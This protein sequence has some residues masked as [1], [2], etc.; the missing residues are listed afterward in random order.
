MIRQAIQEVSPTQA[1]F[2]VATMERVI[3]ESIGTQR[4]Y[5]W[6]MAVFAGI[7]TLLAAA[8][9]YGV[10]AYLVTLRTR[11]FGIR[12]ALGA[13]AGRVLRLVLGHGGWLIALGLAAGTA[14][15]LALTQFLKSV[16]F[17]VSATDTV[18]FVGV[19]ILLAGVAFGACVIPAR[20]AARVDPALALRSD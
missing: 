9:I 2:R 19:G 5:F 4:L 8:G 15:A 7:G 17:G 3:D 10:V 1:T 12:L 20:R 14:G 18:T 11:E 13:D 16:L 6:L